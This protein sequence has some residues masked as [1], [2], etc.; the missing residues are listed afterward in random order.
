MKIAVLFYGQPRFLDITKDRFLEEFSL[1]DHQFDFFM[2][3]WEEIGFTPSCDARDRYIIN[4]NLQKD[5]EYLQPKKYN[6]T[7]YTDLDIL[8]NML[9]NTLNFIEHGKVKYKIH[10]NKTRYTFGQHL[11]LKKAYGLMSKYEEENNFKYDAVIKARPDFIYKD[12]ACYKS[13]EKYIQTK[14]NSYILDFSTYGDNYTHTAALATQE[15]NVQEQKWIMSTINEY[16]PKTQNI[17]RDKYHG[18]RC[19][20][21]GVCCGRSAAN[22]IF[23]KWFDTYIQT[24]IRDIKRNVPTK[25][26][27]HRRHDSLQGEIILNNSITAKR[28]KKSRLHR[29]SYKNNMKDKW[30]NHDCI[31]LDARSTNKR[32]DIENFMKGV[33]T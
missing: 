14:I 3:F 24:F 8:N 20:D 31:C 4:D 2:H 12:K 29:V 26:Q 32:L 7:D 21:V 1:P 10:D 11:S 18:L 25:L 17:N 13:E 19:G 33:K 15:Y 30:L 28:L 27:L 16:N 22:F 9:K 5:V 23:N 6:I